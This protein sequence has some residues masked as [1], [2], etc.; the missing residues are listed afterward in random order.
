M[1]KG[2]AHA[3]VAKSRKVEGGSETLL[4]YLAKPLQ[5]PATQTTKSFSASAE[6]DVLT[7]DWLASNR[8]HSI[9]F[10]KTSFDSFLLFL[11]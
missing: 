2:F 11:L 10:H 4:I 5:G 6:S 8:H 9:E 1:E 7:S 3:K